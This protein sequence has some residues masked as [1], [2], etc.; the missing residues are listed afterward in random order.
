MQIWGAYDNTGENTP[1]DPTDDTPAQLSISAPLTSGDKE[2]L[3]PEGEI[4]LGDMFGLYRYEMCIRD[5]VWTG[6]QDAYADLARNTLETCAE[7]LTRLEAVGVSAMM[8]G[9]LPFDA[10]GNRCV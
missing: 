3:I 9:Y 5:S 2:N 6:I 7:P 10:A 8:H 4:V 1:D